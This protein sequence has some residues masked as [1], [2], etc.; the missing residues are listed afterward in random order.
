QD[1]LKGFEAAR[2]QDVQA[3]LAELTCSPCIASVSSYAKNSIE[4]IVCG[5]GAFNLHLMQ[6]LQAG[7]P[8]CIVRSSDAHGLPALQVEAAAFAWLAQQAV[9]R[10]PGNLSAVTGAAGPRILGGIY[11]A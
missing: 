2:P 4:L 7:L 9:N 8:G 10:Q 6:R 5:G 3:T 11:P 1:K